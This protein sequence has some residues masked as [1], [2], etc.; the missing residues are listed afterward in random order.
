MAQPGNGVSLSGRLR[1]ASGVIVADRAKVTLTG[2]QQTALVTLYGKALD[3]RRPDSIL[4]DRLTDQ[5]VRHIDYD[6]T[7]LRMRRRDQ[8]SSAVR[9]KAYDRLVTRFLDRHPACVVLHLGCGMDT[10]RRISRPVS[11][12]APSR[13]PPRCRRRPQR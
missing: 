8:K 10:R 4:D 12:I 5:A 6:F 9:S 2:T 3:S 11:E 1:S 7:T 13:F